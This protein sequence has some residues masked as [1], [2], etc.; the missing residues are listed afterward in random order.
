MLVLSSNEN[1]ENVIFFTAQVKCDCRERV[2][3]INIV[4]IVDCSDNL[5]SYKTVHLA[6]S[7]GEG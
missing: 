5:I 4:N 1:D 6:N 7:I 3:V 2:N